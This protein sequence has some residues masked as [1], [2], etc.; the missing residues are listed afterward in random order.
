MAVAASQAPGKDVVF[1][2]LKTSDNFKIA[3]TYYKAQKDTMDSIILLH[4]LG[5]NRNDWADLAQKLKA[6]YDVLAIDF[7]G[8][9]ESDGDLDS[10]TAADFNKFMLD[11]RAAAN[12]LDGKGKKVVAIIGASIGANIALNYAAENNIERAVL[13]SPGMDYRGVKTEES[14]RK[15]VGKILFAASED[16]SYSA[17]STRKLYEMTLAKK[18]L[19]IYQ[20]AGHGTG[21]FASTDLDVMIS[22]WLKN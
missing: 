2:E 15:Y 22:S 4:M 18:Q 3:A 13:L 1:M 6:N 16:D 5:R 17:S 11:V 8:H 14:A 19:K 10:F 21:M 20:S 7:R 12:H 9:G